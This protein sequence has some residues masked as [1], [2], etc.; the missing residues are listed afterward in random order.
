MI[1]MRLTP[2]YEAPNIKPFKAL[3]ALPFYLS[4]GDCKTV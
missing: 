2:S 1:I 4:A 3:N